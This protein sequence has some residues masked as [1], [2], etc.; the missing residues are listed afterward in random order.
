M[1]RVIE[2]FFA[3]KGIAFLNGAFKAVILAAIGLLIIYIVNKTIEKILNKSKLETAAH[4]LIKTVAKTVMYA[5]LILII[6]SSLEIDVTGI[7]ALASVLTLAISLAL[8]D[9]LSNV[10]GGFTLIYNKPFSSG[11]YVEIA[12]QSGTVLEIGMAY[13][14]LSTADNKVVSIPNKSV[15]ATEIVNYTTLGTRRIDILVTASYD[16]PIQKVISTLLD[17]A[18]HEK[19]LSAPTPFSAVNQYGDSSIEYVLRFWTK[20]ED[21]WDMYYQVVD[22]IKPMFD[23]AG[24]EMTYPHLNIHVDK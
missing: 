13:T 9:M 12:G 8:Q 6:A 20:S 23:E 2:T 4:G 15:V 10:I 11:D 1:F 21:Y 14:K 3:G 19:I 16:A 24:I 18:K 7:V 5:L 22:K 17:A